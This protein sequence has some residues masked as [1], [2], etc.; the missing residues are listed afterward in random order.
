VA[1]GVLGIAVD[2]RDDGSQDTN[3]MEGG[4]PR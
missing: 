4:S 2:L 1:S 3:P